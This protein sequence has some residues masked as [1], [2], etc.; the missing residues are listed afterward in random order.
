MPF[1]KGALCQCVRTYNM[2]IIYYVWRAKDDGGACR[3]QRR[4]VDEGFYA[5]SEK[6]TLLTARRRRGGPGAVQIEGRG[7]GAAVAVA[8]GSE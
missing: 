3:V 4:R 5:A 1:V 6:E 7:D 8:N 2:R